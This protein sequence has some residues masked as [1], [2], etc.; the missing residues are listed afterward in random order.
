MN[1]KPSSVLHQRNQVQEQTLLITKW[2]KEGIRFVF[3]MRTRNAWKSIDEI[4]HEIG[5]FPGL[6]SDYLAV[7][8]VVKREWKNIAL[9]DNSRDIEREKCNLDKI[10]ETA[11]NIFKP[12]NKEIRSYKHNS[13]VVSDSGNENA[14][15]IHKTTL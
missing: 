2:I 5:D 11:Q 6:C 9:N 12:K 4:R 13:F 1:K 15:S 7:T 14:T 8:N 3:Q 10:S